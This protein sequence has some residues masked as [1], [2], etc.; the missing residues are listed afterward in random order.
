MKYNFNKNINRVKTGS[1]KWDHIK[2]FFGTDDIIPM[3]VADM[4]LP[5]P[6]AVQKALRK[7]L[8]HPVLGYTMRTDDFFKAVQYWLKKKYHWD[9]SNE[10]IYPINSI[11]PAISQAIQGLTDPGDGIIVQP[12]VYN[13]FAELIEYNGRKI[14][15]NN[16]II[17]NNDNPYK[18]YYTIDFND[19][20][21]KAKEAKLFFLCSPHNPVGRVWSHIELE[22]LGNICKK[23]DVK[24]F[25]DEAHSDLVFKRYKHL[26]FGSLKDFKELSIT[27][28]SPSKSF[29]VGGLNTSILIIPNIEIRKKYE[30]IMRKS[31]VLMSDEAIF[32]NVLGLKTLEICYTKCEDWLDA[33]C[34]HLDSNRQLIHDFIENELPMLKISDSESLYMAWINFSSLGLTQ[35]EL[36]DFMKKKAKLGLVS[37]TRF[38]DNGLGFMR[39]NFGC[40][41]KVLEKALK[42]LKKGIIKLK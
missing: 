12:P 8:K 33:L 23:Y 39:L 19:F 14:L 34:E 1:F 32:S 28:M 35:Q 24:I 30:D 37:G 7:R 18:V 25:S 42:Q 38:G 16:L 15:N 31:G 9:I 22:N 2:T 27:A 20:E 13:P 5:I 41:K 40:T 29:N 17:N 36:I 3:H 6:K 11:V 4:D 10:W 21:E 26:P